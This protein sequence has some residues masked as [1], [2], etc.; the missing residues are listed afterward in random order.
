[1]P[2]DAAVL[3]GVLSGSAT[4]DLTLVAMVAIDRYGFTGIM[5]KNHA[6]F[7]RE[8]AFISHFVE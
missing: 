6:L 7:L 8:I 1:L 4:G 5:R 3:R 2:L